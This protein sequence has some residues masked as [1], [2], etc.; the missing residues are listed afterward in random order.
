MKKVIASLV[1]GLVASV[2]FAVTPVDPA[3]SGVAPA[4]KSETAKPVA[5]VKNSHKVVKTHKAHKAHKA[6]KSHKKVVKAV[7]PAPAASATK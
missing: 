3:A 5:P 7:T 1:L 2:S 4:V 6:V